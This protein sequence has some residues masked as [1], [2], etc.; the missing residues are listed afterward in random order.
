VKDLAAIGG[1]VNA[2]EIQTSDALY[3]CLGPVRK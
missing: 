3:T 1:I 2:V